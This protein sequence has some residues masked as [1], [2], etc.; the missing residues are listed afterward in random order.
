[1]KQLWWIFP[2][3]AR[4][5][6][7]HLSRAEYAVRKKAQNYTHYLLKMHNMEMTMEWSLCD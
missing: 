7:F 4:E 6:S 5:T 2:K 3:V 1:M